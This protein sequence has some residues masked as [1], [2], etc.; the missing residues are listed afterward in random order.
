MLPPNFLPAAYAEW[1]Q[2][3]VSWLSEPREIA[4]FIGTCF[5][6]FDLLR[7]LTE[8]EKVAINRQFEWTTIRVRL[9]DSGNLRIE[10]IYDNLR[11]EEPLSLI[12]TLLVQAP[13]RASHEEMILPDYLQRQGLSRELILPYYRQYQY[14]DVESILIQAG[15]SGGGYAWAKYGFAATVPA[16][17]Y[18]IL[19]T[20]PSRGI[21]PDLVE[22][23][24]AELGAFYQRSTEPFPLEPWAQL[25]FGEQLL[26][27][28]LWRGE[29][30]LR[31]P[32]QVEIFEA[33][34]YGR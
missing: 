10:H 33:Y 7:L 19:D 4:H 21:A 34:L 5:A 22:E 16:E 14:A 6:G 13:R 28:T 23:L 3:G 24:R 31:N 17:V 30:N 25:P 11:D 27:G 9:M 2:K 20:A 32:R 29:L 8:L 12:R 18:R 1:E 26:A 15:L